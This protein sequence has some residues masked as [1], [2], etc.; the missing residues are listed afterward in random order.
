MYCAHQ[1]NLGRSLCKILLIDTNRICP[2]IAR[3]AIT[4][5]TSQKSPKT[6]THEQAS[7]IGADIFLICRITP[8]VGEGSIIGLL[9]EADIGQVCVNVSIGVT[10]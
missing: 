5:Q 6:A 3:L 4:V 7:A 2:K 8:N 9:V 1:L 10:R